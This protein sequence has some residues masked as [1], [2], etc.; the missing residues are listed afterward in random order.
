MGAG[1]RRG[2]YNLLHPRDLAGSLLSD[3]DNAMPGF[4]QVASHMNVLCWKVL[5]DE[6]VI[7]FA[8]SRLISRC[9]QVKGTT[10]ANPHLHKTGFA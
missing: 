8:T 10:A 9:P 6:K 1:T 7:Q 3:A 4:R 5:M 2:I